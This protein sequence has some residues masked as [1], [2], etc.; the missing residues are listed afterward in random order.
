LEFEKL[1]K[2]HKRNK[3][4]SGEPKVDEWIKTKARQAQEKR[5][6][7]TNV[8]CDSKAVVGYYTIAIGQLSLEELPEAEFKKLPKGVV[9]IVT[10]AWLGLDIS[11]QGRGLGDKLFVHALA[12]CYKTGLNFPYVAVIIDCMNEKAKKFYE[13]YDF[14]EIVGHP[15][16]LYISWKRLE[17]IANS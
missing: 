10:L 9:P 12:H 2:H 8:L 7:I 15:M 11:M 5:L 6:S 3:F 16:K 17:V 13:R 14:K 4:N 1:S